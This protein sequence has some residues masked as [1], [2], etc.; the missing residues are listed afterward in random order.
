MVQI[1]R[2]GKYPL[3]GGIHEIEQGQANQPPGVGEGYTRC[4]GALRG[5]TCAALDCLDRLD[6]EA[7]RALLAA[8]FMA[9]ERCTAGFCLAS[10]LAVKPKLNASASASARNLIPSMLLR[11]AGKPQI[12]L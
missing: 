5:L 3:D 1:I 8:F 7:F 11:H 10:M 4:F 12:H 6:F 9:F 2:L